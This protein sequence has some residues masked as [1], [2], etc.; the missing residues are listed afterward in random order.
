MQGA[1]QPK[2]AF[3]WCSYF[4][5]N[6]KSFFWVKGLCDCSLMSFSTV[7]YLHI[8]QYQSQ[9]QRYVSNFLNTLGY[10]EKRQFL[11]FTPS[12]SD[13]IVCWNY[14]L[15]QGR[16][17]MHSAVKRIH[18]TNQYSS[19]SKRQICIERVTRDQTRS[20]PAKSVKSKITFV[21]SKIVVQTEYKNTEQQSDV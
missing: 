20:K 14:L 16:R 2:N 12:T 4:G 1:I 21:V 7:P 10:L 9:T 18:P 15:W 5:G 19:S 3:F 6:I 17:I 8:E 11:Y 13:W